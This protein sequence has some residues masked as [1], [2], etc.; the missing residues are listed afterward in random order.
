M[1]QF[2][3]ISGSNCS[4]DGVYATTEQRVAGGGCLS[5]TTMVAEELGLEEGSLTGT[6]DLAH[7][8]QVTRETQINF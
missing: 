2:P 8:Q 7:N 5:L 4:Y 6:W 3:N 1:F